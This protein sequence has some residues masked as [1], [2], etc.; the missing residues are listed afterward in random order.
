MISAVAAMALLI[1]AGRGRCV[2]SVL[3]EGPPEEGGGDVE[4]IAPESSDPIPLP[5]VGEP[6][7]VIP[8][9]PPLEPIEPSEPLEPSA[10]SEL[11]P[12]PAPPEPIEESAGG[13]WFDAAPQPTP[14]AAPVVSS[15]PS[16]LV[17]P[18]TE[19]EPGT[20]AR[21][22]TRTCPGWP[23]LV[24]IPYMIGDAAAGAGGGAAI[25]FAGVLGATVAQPTFAG[26]RL[27][28]ADANSPLPTDRA[29][30]SYRHLSNASRVT[31]GQ[32][33]ENADLDHHLVAWERTFWDRGASL[34]LRVPIEH[35]LT[36]NL[37][38]T[39]VPPDPIDLVDVPG[40]GRDTELGNISLIFKA[41][42]VA[43]PNVAVTS[44]VGL[45]APTARDVK[46]DLF[47][48]NASVLP[49]FLPFIFDNHVGSGQAEIANETV[50]LSPFL[51]WVAAPHPRWFH[52]G[53][54]QV[55]I[56]TNPSHV[57]VSAVGSGDIIDL[58]IDP[59]VSNPDVG[60][61]SYTTTT[62]QRLHLHAQ[63]LMRLNVGWGYL[64]AERQSAHRPSSL[65]ALIELHYTTTLD[66]PS[67]RSVLATTASVP[68]G[69]PLPQGF[70]VGNSAE[71]VDQLN[72]ST[73]L[74]GQW[75]PW[76][77]TGAVVSPIRE[78]PDRSFDVQFNGQIHR[79]F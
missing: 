23:E 40:D 37:S 22:T 73:G 52:Q 44:G 29:Y 72:V 69:F 42:L 12:L 61:F 24:N 71:R 28:I 79:Q 64:L 2:A 62:P 55:D 18:Y 15:Y 20:Y 30:Y 77:I 57:T 7:D 54:L 11:I 3:F 31:V 26:S 50:Y 45:M 14:D 17:V 70:I 56:P 34:E 63:P 78:F 9:G 25:G 49:D 74:S 1:S 19:L 27:N 76:V 53:F 41:L 35:R 48:S 8:Q 75:G 60:D 58:R 32:F 66:D 4:L 36:S 67:N 47:V 21:R 10:P 46:Y 51:A 65:A 68:P 43:Q 5:P 33:E 59:N 6:N 13:T 38:S 16:T 39:A